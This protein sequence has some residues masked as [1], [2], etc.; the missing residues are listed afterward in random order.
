MGAHLGTLAML[1]IAVGGGDAALAGLAAIAV[2]AG[3]HGAAGLAPEEAGVAEHAVETGS[4]RFALYCGRARHHHGDDARRDAPAAHHV[5]GG[6]EVGQA[7]IG[8]RP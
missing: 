4:L 3:A 6:S 2:A 7:T 1:E 5:G 8:A